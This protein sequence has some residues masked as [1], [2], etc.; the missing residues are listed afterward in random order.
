MY[1][2]I[3]KDVSVANRRAINMTAYVHVKKFR[4]VGGRDDMFKS[5]C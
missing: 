4:Q 5:C 3:L 2:E 1:T